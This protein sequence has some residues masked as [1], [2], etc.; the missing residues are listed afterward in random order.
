MTNKIE[1]AWQGEGWY[2]VSSAISA[3]HKVAF[4]AECAD[5]V[6]RA[7]NDLLA[8]YP[9]DE[10]VIDYHGCGMLPDECQYP[11]FNTWIDVDP[12]SA[13]VDAYNIAQDIADAKSKRDANAF[14]A[15]M[16]EYCDY[17]DSDW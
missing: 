15:A 10:Q 7:S 14:M 12:D 8:T 2:T 16:K 5:D 13:T 4:W 17:C 11:D 1:N 6:K 9:N 3:G